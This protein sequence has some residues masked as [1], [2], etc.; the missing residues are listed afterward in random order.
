M[1]FSETKNNDALEQALALCKGCYQ[2]NFILGFEAMSGSTLKGKARK[3]SCKYAISRFNLLT[4]MTNAGISWSEKRGERGKR[5]L[6][7]G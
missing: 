5:I 7:I 6:V 4:R 1:S 3:Y 2:R